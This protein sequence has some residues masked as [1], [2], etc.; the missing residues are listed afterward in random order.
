MGCRHPPLAGRGDGARQ[1][2]PQGGFEVVTVAGEQ[3]GG[4]R[5]VAEGKRRPDGKRNGKRIR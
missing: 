4:V 3:D 1:L 5:W 2:Q